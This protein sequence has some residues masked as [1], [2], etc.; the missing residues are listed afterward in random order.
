MRR[1]LKLR[2][3]SCATTLVRSSIASRRAKPSP[4][5]STAGPSPSSNPWDGGPAGFPRDE[6]VRHVVAHQADSALRAEL[7]QLAPD[8]TDD[9]PLT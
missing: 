1:W 9:P 3:G 8:T 5:R 7:R 2:P 6:F 4:S